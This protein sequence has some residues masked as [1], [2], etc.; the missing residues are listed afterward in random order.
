MLSTHTVALFCHLLGVLL[1][2]SGIVLAAVAF[3]TAR[4]R[5]EP[6]EIA[7]ILALARIGVLLVVPGALLVLGF[8]LWLVDLGG[9]ASTPSG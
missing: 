2:T 1:L 8:G 4:R 5:Q 6:A 9:S 7:L 3:E